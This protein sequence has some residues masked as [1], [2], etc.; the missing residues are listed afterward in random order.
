[1]SD[2]ASML[3][4]ALRTHLVSG[5]ALP[6]PGSGRWG[7]TAFS[8]RLVELAGQGSGAALSQGMSLVV[9]AQ[10]AGEPVVWITCRQPAFYPP[11]AAANGVDLAAMPVIRPPDA[12]AGGRAAWYLLRSGAFGMAVLDLGAHDLP[13]AA[14]ARLARLAQKHEATVIYLTEQGDTRS[15]GQGLVSL[16]ARVSRRRAAA[17]R[18]ECTVTALKDKRYGPG[19][20]HTET[21][22]GPP[23]LR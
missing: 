7:L 13:A 22:C 17:N 23:G 2:V 16:R 18:F 14:H 5:D 10:H 21:L 19:W 3:P 8:G 4:A 9:E 1:M 6:T 20:S 11:D 12:T 15:I